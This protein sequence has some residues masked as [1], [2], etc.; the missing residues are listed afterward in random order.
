MSYEK[1]MKHSRNVRKCRKQSGNYMGFDAGTGAWPNPRRN[2][3]TRLILQLRD[4]LKMRHF[5]DAAHNR[6]CIRESIAELRELRTTPKPEPY[7]T[8]LTP[9]GEQLV[10]PGCERQDRPKT[11]QLS[12]F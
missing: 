10:I 7:R 4:W 3:E 6:A 11:A 8:E 5:D 2:P 12:L 1:A 9:I